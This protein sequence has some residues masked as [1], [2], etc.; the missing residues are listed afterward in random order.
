MSSHAPVA[1]VSDEEMN[2]VLGVIDEETGK[3]VGE[4]AEET[5]YSPRNVQHILA[6]LMERGKITSTPDWEYR[7]S[8]RSDR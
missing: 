7:E 5:G 4:L 8:R 3:S 6:A 1:E 2:T